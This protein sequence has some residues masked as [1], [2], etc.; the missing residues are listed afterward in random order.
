[1]I[2]VRKAKSHTDA[3]NHRAWFNL[4]YV[5]GKLGVMKNKFSAGLHHSGTLT[6][7]WFDD[8]HNQDAWDRGFTTNV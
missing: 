3:E 5:L 7:V 8:E 1:M 6:I 2:K 4:L